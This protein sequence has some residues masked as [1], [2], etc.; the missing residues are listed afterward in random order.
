MKYKMDNV[1][2]ITKQKLDRCDVEVE[3]GIG[4]HR[5]AIKYVDFLIAAQ[6]ALWSQS[7]K[8]MQL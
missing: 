7:T 2:L 1:D 4:L 8:S 6:I 5:Y 3:N